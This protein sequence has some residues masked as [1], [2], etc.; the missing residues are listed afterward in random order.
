LK[1][2]HKIKHVLFPKSKA[3]EQ[4]ELRN[5]IISVKKRGFMGTIPFMYYFIYVKD[6]LK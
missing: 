3:E 2:K 1:I 5:C 6:I 4:E